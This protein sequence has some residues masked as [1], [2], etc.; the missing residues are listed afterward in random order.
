MVLGQHGHGLEQA[1]QL[2]Y[3]KKFELSAS[4]PYMNINGTLNLCLDIS[5]QRL[6]TR[7]EQNNFPEAANIEI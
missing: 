3:G 5:L 1:L 4:K 2:V 7:E 6:A